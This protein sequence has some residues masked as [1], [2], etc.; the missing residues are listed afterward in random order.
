MAAFAHTGVASYETL[1]N[2]VAGP[3]PSLNMLFAIGGNLGLRGG[4]V[5]VEVLH[6]L[7][8]YFRMRL[9]NGHLELLSL[10]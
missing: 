3:D 10:I 1:H 4:L 6:L 8:D 2:A 9:L 5:T 7:E